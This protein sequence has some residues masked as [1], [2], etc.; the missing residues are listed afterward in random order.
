MTE[1]FPLSWPQGWPRT[2]A[3]RRRK[4]K[5]GSN[6]GIS[7]HTKLRNELRLLG[8]TNVVISSN[9]AVR[10]DGLPYAAEGRRRYD[11]PGV[12][13]WFVLDGKPRSMARDPYHTPWENVRSLVL[14]IEAMRSLER[15]GGSAMVERAFEG[16]AALP[17]PKAKRKWWDVLEV[18]PS[19]PRYVIEQNFK[20][21][22]RD[23]HPDKHGGSSERM[24]ELNVARDE[25]LAGEL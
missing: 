14:A 19:S 9:V 2:P 11:D 18:S 5:F 1:A 12:A 13:V 8:A 15:H 10:G 21:L 16:F 7:Q 20:R 24:S 17:A 3:G 4:S 23:W 22:A 6:L 25:A